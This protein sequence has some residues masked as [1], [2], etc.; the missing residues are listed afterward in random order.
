MQT[1]VTAANTVIK[2]KVHKLITLSFRD[3]ILCLG[4]IFVIHQLD[5]DL[6]HLITIGVE[7]IYEEALE[8]LTRLKLQDNGKVTQKDD[9]LIPH[10]EVERFLTKLMANSKKFKA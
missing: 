4:G 2:N 6:I 9:S 3:L 10:P 5:E 7:E 8:K 1:A